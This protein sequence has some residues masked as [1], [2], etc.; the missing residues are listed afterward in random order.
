MIVAMVIISLHGIKKLFTEVDIF[1]LCYRMM[2]IQLMKLHELFMSGS[3][4]QNYFSCEHNGFILKDSR[5][6]FSK[7]ILISHFRNILV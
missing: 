6:Y 2:L 7:T 4:P 1:Y 3:V 5:I